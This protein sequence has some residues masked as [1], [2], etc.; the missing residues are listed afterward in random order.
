LGGVVG[1]KTGNAKKVVWWWPLPVPGGGNGDGWTNRYTLAHR[2][3]DAVCVS[4]KRERRH[5]F[6]PARASN[7]CGKS[8]PSLPSRS[9]ADRCN[10]AAPAWRRSSACAASVVAVTRV[11]L[12]ITALQADV[13]MRWRRSPLHHRGCVDGRCG[14]EVAVDS[15]RCCSV[16]SR[17]SAPAEN[18]HTG[19]HT[20][21]LTVGLF[22]V[23]FGNIPG[24]K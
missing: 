7:G 9:A 12:W 19:H 11:K 4:S 14:C 18:S 17:R 20:S 3:A 2:N 5:R 6:N 8:L 10:Y 13:G 24:E 15:V 22:F 16:R 21:L 1:E 23:V